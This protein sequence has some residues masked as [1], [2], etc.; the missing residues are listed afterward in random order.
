M[1]PNR[2]RHDGGT[3]LSEL[4]VGLWYD[5][6]IMNSAPSGVFVDIGAETDA[7]LR[8]PKKYISGL[9]HDQDVQVEV[10]E[11][12]SEK[13]RLI[14]RM[15]ESDWPEPTA[16]RGPA[17]ETG[18]GD[19]GR[20]VYARDGAFPAAGGKGRGRGPAGRDRDA[21]HTR[22][23]RN[24]Q[25][26]PDHEARVPLE[27]LQAGS[28]VD[29]IVKNNNSYGVFLDIGAQSDARLQIPKD[30]QR[31]FQRGDELPN[32]VIDWV[33]VDMRRIQVLVPEDC[34]EFMV[35][36]PA[37]LAIK[38]APEHRPSAAE[39]TALAV[40]APRGRGG[41]AKAAA[42]APRGG[43]GGARAP[44]AAARRAAAGDPDDEVGRPL[45]ELMEGDYADGYV[46]NVTNNGV[47]VEIGYQKHAR[48]NVPRD[49]WTQFLVNDE[50]LGMLV[51]KVDLARRLVVVS[52]EDPEL[53][54]EEQGALLP[55]AA[56]APP[57]AAKAKAKGKPK[58]KALPVPPTALSAPAGRIEGRRAIMPPPAAPG[59]SGHLR[60]G[61]LL[62]G[63]VARVTAQAVFVDIVGS[64]YA[65]ILD[66]PKELRVQFRNGD[67]I[68]GMKVDIVDNRS[69]RVTLSLED[70][71]LETEEVDGAGD[72][73]PPMIEGP[74]RAKPKP[75]GKAARTAAKAPQ[76]LALPAPEPAPPLPEKK[77][78]NPG[79]AAR[80]GGRPTRAKGTPLEKLVL[81]QEVIG[82]VTKLNRIGAF[83]DFGAVVDGKLNVSK[84]DAA[85]F[86]IGD[87]V[88]GV[89][90]EHIDLNLQRVDLAL[91]YE[92]GDA[93]AEEHA[94]PTSKAAMKAK[95]KA[96]TKPPEPR[97]RPFPDFEL[98]DEQGYSFNL[99]CFLGKRTMLYWYPRAGTPGCTTEAK[100][101]MRLSMDYSMRGVQIVGA[102]SD[103][104][105]ENGVFAERCGLD[106]PLLC[107]EERTLPEALG[108]AGS[109][110]AVL[111]AA[112]GTIEQ[113]WPAVNAKNF[114]S[115]AL[116]GL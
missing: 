33:D 28:L 48:L 92:L 89:L 110:W 86:E 68:H 108:M 70:P 55:V 66:V 67:Q 109:R 57:R 22:P 114:P 9:R 54:T 96:M 84:E 101:F 71:L 113:V 15:D 1:V 60:V 95:A 80:Q 45:E 63:S 105:E 93:P 69:K 3:P 4:E 59:S 40:P 30:Q 77:A 44:A 21:H 100:E 53:A 83:L 42:G 58:H 27:E 51:E 20:L 73:M 32:C 62:D 49:M 94:A 11:L 61:S 74:S 78:Q 50:I 35:A 39:M 25:R 14:V 104:Q 38:A 10:V 98:P 102:S 91:P 56:A 111:V 43:G 47:Y 23:P 97:A 12:D 46:A 87:Q 82:I 106:F 75:K 5:G 17:A 88:E 52:L 2:R 8:I 37:P 36:P 79:P 7:R 90:V 64:E 41:R 29:G 34:K 65:G 24:F 13:L 72:E 85:K 16:R 103:T 99:E 19:G 6:T 18:K 26:Q 116:A 107:D 31:Y 115:E 81:G 112:D 76:Q